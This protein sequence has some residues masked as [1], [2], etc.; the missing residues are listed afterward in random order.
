MGTKQ[1]SGI[2][3]KGIGGFYYVEAAD[4]VYECRARGIFRKE[5][6]TPVAGDYVRI[7][8]Q[9]GSLTDGSVDEILPRKNVLKRPPVAN[10]DQLFVVASLV[11]PL[12]NTLLMDKLIGIAERHHID[13]VVLVNKCD[14]ED[15]GPLCQIY[16]TAGIP[17]IAVS[18]KT[19]EG[20][21]R[22]REML[23]GKLN[24]FTGNSGVGKSSILNQLFPRLELPTGDISRK[25]G[26]G[27]HTTRQ[28]ELF[29]LE[30]GG[31]LADT[32]GFSSVDLE[33][34]EVI[35]KDQ[36]PDCFREFG[37]YLG[38]CQFTSCAHIGEK[39][40]RVKQA[41]DEGKIH[42]SRYENYV[43]LY[44]QVKNIKEWEIR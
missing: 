43:E 6:I 14:L 15:A 7:T 27:R 28:V 5:K 2:I 36:L 31:Y 42:P 17:A 13:P 10:V 8:V 1:L 4:A 41:V 38:A 30:G 21:D 19:G 33:K 24:V 11:D 3:Q 29:P 18:A 26:R 12:P 25:L 20:I 44:H 9:E 34:C 23:S 40:C 35:L 39:G 32:P 16:Q 37:P 22:V